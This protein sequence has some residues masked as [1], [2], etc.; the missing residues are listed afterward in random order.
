MF[1]WE[2]Q[3]KEAASIYLQKGTISFL[4]IFIFFFLRNSRPNDEEYDWASQGAS[5]ASKE[6]LPAWVHDAKYMEMS[7]CQGNWL[8]NMDKVNFFFVCVYGN[9]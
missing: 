9:F 6:G 5:G 4:A 1:M 7:H 2:A 3:S 8:P